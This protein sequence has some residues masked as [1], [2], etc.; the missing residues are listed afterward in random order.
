MFIAENG[1]R[2]ATAS[3]PAAKAIVV[4]RTLGDCRIK[5][6]AEWPKDFLLEGGNRFSSEYVAELIGDIA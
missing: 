1:A 4:T 3:I 5:F 6:F 2:T